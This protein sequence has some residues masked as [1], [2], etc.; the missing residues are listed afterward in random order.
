MR[1]YHGPFGR[2]CTLDATI[3][4]GQYRWSLRI[5]RSYVKE[6]YSDELPDERVIQRIFV[7]DLPVKI[8]SVLGRDLRKLRAKVKESITYLENAMQSQNKNNQ[9]STTN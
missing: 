4:N 8:S 6:Y 7:D 3:E 5:G 1:P 9:K 2:H